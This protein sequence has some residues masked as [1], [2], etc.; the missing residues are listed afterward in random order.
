[1][2]DL[3][4]LE[5][6]RAGARAFAEQITAQIPHEPAVTIEQIEVPRPDGSTLLV[7]LV[8]PTA[9]TGPLPALTWLHAGGQVMGFAAEDDPYLT[10][11][12][13]QVGLVAAAVDYRLAPEA[14]APAAAQDGLLAYRWL[15]AH[16]DELGI[17]PGRVALAGNSGGA[18]I[19]AATAL[20]IRDR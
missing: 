12:C 11:L 19:A 16:A 15:H 14:P 9:P 18:G 20:M 10:Q 5:G 3:N 2:F 4:D 6:T 13:L 7:R 17:D 8:R 1:M